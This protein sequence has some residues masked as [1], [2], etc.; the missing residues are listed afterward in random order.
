MK[1]IPFYMIINKLYVMSFNRYVKYLKEQILNTKWFEKACKDKKVVIKYLSKDFF[2]EIS[3]NIYF[4]YENFK[5]CF[6]KLLLIKFEYKEELE[7][8]NHLKLLNINI[9]NETRFKV[10]EF[11]LSM[12]KRFLETN[13][14]LYMKLIDRKE[15]VD[16]FFKEYNRY[17][18]ISILSK[19]LNHTYFF[20]NKTVYKLDYL[21]PKKRFIYSIYIKDIINTNLN[22]LK[23]DTQ[24]SKLIYEKY[25]TKLSRRVICDIRKKYSIPKITKVQRFNQKMLFTN[26][27]SQKRVLNKENIA[28]LPNDLQGVY[29]LS[30]SKLEM[31]PFLTNKVIYIGSSKNIKRRLRAYTE[32]YAHTKE[33][34]EFIKSCDNVY[35][36]VV[37]SKDYRVFE[38]RFIEYFIYL[39]GELPKFNTQ[40]VLL[41]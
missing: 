22:I 14:C 24:I 25:D 23:N 16:N 41:K 3:S 37:K 29:E 33:I 35:F 32:K 38:K 28:Q 26:S 15:F 30:S 1:N 21:V 40:R 11:L 12:Q 10:I 9:V 20:F 36:R 17:L 8:N 2:T 39:H 6:Y 5:S 18:D 34:K 19:I 13:H 27:F 7:D 4:K 31:Y